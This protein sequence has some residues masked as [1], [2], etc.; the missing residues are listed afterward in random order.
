MKRRSDFKCSIYGFPKD[1]TGSQLPTIADTVRFYNFS[2]FKEG[3]YISTDKLSKI[4]SLF[5]FLTLH[6]IFVVGGTK[7]SECLEIGRHPNN[8]RPSNCEKGKKDARRYQES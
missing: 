5:E 1:L 8:H 7:N 4:V 6:Q 2:R 3:Y